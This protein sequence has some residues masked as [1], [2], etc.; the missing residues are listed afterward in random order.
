M[1]ER[2]IRLDDVMPLMLEKLSAGQSVSFSPRGVS[3]LPLIKEGRDSVTL[4]PVEGRLRRFDVPLYRRK[5]GQYVLHRVVRVGD[6]YTCVGDNQ[7][8]LEEGITDGQVIAVMTSMVRK[9]KKITTKDPLYRLYCIF[10]HYSRLPRRVLRALV[11]RV[12]RIFKA[13]I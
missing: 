3:M 6:S 5:N 13:Y 8:A 1:S 10:W 7:F 12:K 2:N 11:I 9:G 4:S